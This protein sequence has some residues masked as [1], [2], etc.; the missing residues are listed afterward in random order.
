MSHYRDIAY[1]ATHGQEITLDE[2][3]TV[4]HEALLNTTILVAQIKLLKE[5]LCQKDSQIAQLESRLMALGD[6]MLLPVLEQGVLDKTE[7]A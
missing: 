7:V 1:R 4:E 5:K 3:M 2:V 6:Y